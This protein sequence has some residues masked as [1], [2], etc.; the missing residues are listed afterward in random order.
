ML[1]RLRRWQCWTLLALV[2][3]PPLALAEETLTLGIFAYRPKAIMAEK[4]DMLGVYLTGA[5]PG[6]QLKVEYLDLDELDAAV[7]ADRLDFIFTNPAHFVRLRHK[8]QL[9]GAIATLQ[10]LESGKVTAGLGGV[11]LVPSENSAIHSLKDLRGKRI[12]IP[13]KSFLGGYQ[14]QAFEALEVGVDLPKDST[15]IEAGGHDKVVEALLAGQAEAGFVRTGLIESMYQKGTLPPGRLRVIN[16]QNPPYF[17]FALSTRIYPEWAFAAF[18]RVPEDVVKR[19]NR[20]LLFITPDMPVATDAGIAG[21][22]VPGDYQVVEQL[23]RRLRLPPYE[24]AEFH[25]GD[26][27]QRYHWFLLTGILALALILALSLRLATDH[28]LLARTGTRLQ[29]I[30]SRVPGVVYEFQL[31]SD[32]SACFPYASEAIRAIYRV[33]PEAVRSDASKVIAVLHPDDRD[34]VMASIQASADSLQTWQQEYRVKFPDGTVRWLAGNAVPVREADG[35]TLWHGYISDISERKAVEQELSAYRDDLELQVKQRTLALSIAKEAA[36]AASRAK[37]SFLANMSH[38]LRTP[39]NA[40]IGLTH[41][42]S[43]SALDAAQKDKVSK[44]QNAAN[45]LLQL[46]NDVLDLSKID[47]EQLTLERVSFNLSDLAS[48]IDSLLGGRAA[49]RQVNLVTDIAPA[50]AQ[51]MLIGDPLRLQEVLINL[52][53]NAVKFT[54]QGHVILRVQIAAESPADVTLAFRVEDTGIGMT[55]EVLG[56]IFTPFEQAD[57]SITRKHGG[58]GLGL[59]ICQ[60][61]VRLMQGE[62]TVT[63]T[64]GQGSIF[65]FTLKFPRGGQAVAGS[66]PIEDSAGLLAEAELRAHFSGSRILIAEDDWV[67]QEVILELIRDILGFTVDLA[68][69]GAE[70]VELVQKNDYALVLMDMQMPEMDGLEA[71]QT[72]RQLPGKAA[73]VQI[74][75]MTANA[76]AEDRAQCLEAGMNDFLAKP[77]DPDLLFITMLRALSSARG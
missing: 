72:I 13:G 70:A 68:Q 36:E 12:A 7:A 53:G 52:V 40:I 23:A 17:P 24:Q 28:R 19:V 32:G 35:S 59:A 57:A 18:A 6:Y 41:L 34:A 8:N 51:T 10:S 5:L 14:T 9:S 29:R 22:T 30:A 60:R 46:L 27:W 26:V 61:L 65:A 71:T 50:V 62:I 56:R 48:K 73:Q 66:E 38:E 67:N 3:W 77:V 2:A 37:G 45:H 25:F 43:R 74:V 58:T 64:P 21:F 33:T 76:F 42:L 44:V 69:N 63:S 75:A 4:F 16:T 55:P 31:R 20:A 54:E 1:A 11:I 15:L 47:A 39:M 49:A